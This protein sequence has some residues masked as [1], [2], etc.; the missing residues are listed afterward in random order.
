MIGLSGSNIF[1]VHLVVQMTGQEW[2]EGQA[3]TYNGSIE[4]IGGMMS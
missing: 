1:E 2:K 4:D 3:E